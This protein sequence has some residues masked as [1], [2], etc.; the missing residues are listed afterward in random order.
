V[1]FLLDTNVMIGV[2]RNNPAIRRKLRFVPTDQ[3]AT[4][5]IVMHELYYGA[6]KGTE[7]A[8]D[9]A[10]LAALPVE[11]IDFTPEDA[12]RAGEIRAY[13]QARGTPIGP[14]DIL[15]A[16]QALARELTLVT[17]NIRE[18]SRIDGLRVENWEA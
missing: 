4:S 3:V 2:M 17:R 13:L 16:G 9:L 11:V 12:F 18:F 1:S 14:Y 15:I 8:A 5:S 6:Y 10:I 7:T